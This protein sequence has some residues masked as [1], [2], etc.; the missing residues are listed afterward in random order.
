MIGTTLGLYLLRR[1][2]WSIL[3]VFAMIAALIALVDFVE[4]FRRVSDLPA[5]SG[6]QAGLLTLMR[7]PSISEQVLP[8]AVLGGSM[9]GFVTLSRKLE[10]V[11]ARAAGVSVWQFLAPP[12]LIVALIG[13]FS[14]VAYNPAAALLKE[15]ADAIE[16]SLFG[17]VDGSDSDASLWIRQSSVDGQAILRAEHSSDKGTILADVSV[18]AFS[19]DD[20]FQERIEAARARLFPGYWRLENAR[21][22]TPGQPPRAAA[23]YLLATN[24]TPAQVVQSF[25]EPDSV[26]FW[27]L[28]DVVRR[29]EQAGLNATAYRLQYQSLLARPLL[30]VAMVLIAACFSLRFFRF[31]GVAGTAAGGVVA[32]FVLYVVTKLVGDL[33]GAG[34]LSAPVAAWSPAVVASMLGALVLLH[35]EDG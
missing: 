19:D 33:G 35:Q 14:V 21:I 9:I 10:L 15:R 7:V 8:F 5:G 11:V 24:L 20:V 23:V 34:L 2:A 27:E 12:I 32:G 17:R 13:I 3:G 4:M 29:T 6:A 28:R 22:T 26:P 16:T 30:L 31:G 1:F 25:V 18:F